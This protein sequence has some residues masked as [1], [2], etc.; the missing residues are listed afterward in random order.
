MRKA[1]AM[2]LVGALGVLSG[3][4]IHLA[5]AQQQGETIVFLLPASGGQPELNHR[6]MYTSG[7]VAT[8]DAGDC[9]TGQQPV[10]NAVLID[11]GGAPPSRIIGIITIRS[12]A[13]AP[14]TRLDT[15]TFDANCAIGGTAYKRYNG[16][17]Q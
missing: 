14:G 6:L 1:F 17:V 4:T 3:A 15:L 9:G 13:P 8:T 2:G 7:R 16:T 10:Q 11:P 5:S 12:E